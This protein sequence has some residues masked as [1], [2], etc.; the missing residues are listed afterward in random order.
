MPDR[1]TLSLQAAPVI[2]KGIPAAKGRARAVPRIVW[3]DGE[4]EAIVN[5]VT[6]EDTRQAERAIRAAFKRKYPRH[7]PWAGPIRLNF[8][9]VFAIPTTFSKK[10]REQARGGSLFVT[11]KPD[12][13][14][15]EKLIVDALNKVAFHDDSQIIGGGIKIYGTLP[16]I[17]FSLQRLEQEATPAERAAERNRQAQLP[18]VTGKPAR[19]APAPSPVQ[20]P[21]GFNPYGGPSP[22]P[23]I[24]AHN[25]RTQAAIRAALEREDRQR[26]KR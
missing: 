19:P 16:R 2:R 24:S 4:P 7:L 10:L 23:D 14:N 3:K 6:P 12:K 20:N 13:D 26:G 8:T 25:P 11:K 22:A 15:I 17:E 5:L 1:L 18:L 21:T 9:A